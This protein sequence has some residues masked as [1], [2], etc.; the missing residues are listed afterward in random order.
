[1]GVQGIQPNC[2]NSSFFGDLGGMGEW[3]LR[4]AEET[5]GVLGVFGGVCGNGFVG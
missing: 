3:G 1:M 4:G 5:P 2:R